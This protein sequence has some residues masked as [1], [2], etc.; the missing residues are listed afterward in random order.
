M[1]VS[2]V[3]TMQTPAPFLLRSPPVRTAR[4]LAHTPLRRPR[5]LSRALLLPP[6]FGALGLA[7]ALSL[8]RD[9][10]E[11]LKLG[12][13]IFA[14]GLI[15]P[16]LAAFLPGRLR[17]PARGAIAA[18]IAGGTTAAVGRFVPG[19]FRGWDP[20]VVGTAVNAVILSSAFVASR[21]SSL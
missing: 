7:T 12:Y 4:H 17:I 11:T 18:M 19:L 8:D 21:R 14:A 10:L 13:S 16:V 1:L 3:A 15:L 6:V 9:V 20:V 2:L 5:P